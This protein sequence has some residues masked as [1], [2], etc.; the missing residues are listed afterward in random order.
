M[1]AKLAPI[2]ERDG[3]QDRVLLTDWH[4]IGFSTDFAPGRPYPAT[5]LERDLVV[6]RET[7]GEIHVWEDLCIHRG[8]RLSKGW[9]QNNRLICPYHGWNYN[10]AGRCTMMPVAPEEAPMKKAAAFTYP[11]V[12]R[13]GFVWTCLGEPRH[14]LPPFPE[15]E[16]ANFEKVHS[17]PY[18]YEANGYRSI[19]NFLD[20]THF[21]FV[22]AG[23][24]GVP[25][26]PDR[27]KPYTVELTPDGLKSSEVEVFQ[28]QGDFRGVPVMGFYTYRALRPLVAY[29]SKR[30]QDADHDGNIISEK[31]NTFTTLFTVQAISATRSVARICAALDIKPSPDPEATRARADVVYN[32]DRAIVETQRPERLPLELR[33][34]LHHRTDLMGQKY[35]TWLRDLGVTYGVY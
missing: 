25:E 29:F 32:Q 10:G 33:Y 24:N 13:Y 23:L 15:W 4:V 5:L 2:T 16:D 8:A 26:K 21:P 27:L 28:P 14:G 18:C 31:S 11:A 22:H 20:A 12:E 7:S 35:R 19:E 30:T 34:E 17:G 9:V 3:C 1:S 6:W